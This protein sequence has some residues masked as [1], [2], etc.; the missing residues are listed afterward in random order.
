MA[1][2]A[3]LSLFSSQGVAA[4]ELFH[5]PNHYHHTKAVRNNIEDDDQLNGYCRVL[6]LRSKGAPCI[7]HT[8]LLG[9][10]LHEYIRTIILRETARLECA[11]LGTYALAVVSTLERVR[12]NC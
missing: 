7:N 3:F 10:K 1:E 5:A 4:V 2:G 11:I 9:Y 6:F 12:L 8:A